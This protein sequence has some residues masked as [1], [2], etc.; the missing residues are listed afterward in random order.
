MIKVSAL[1]PYTDGAEF[2]M[3]YYVRQHIPMVQDLLGAALKGISVEHGV[4]G[5]TPDAA[6]VYV[7]MGH[8]LFD[9]TAAFNEAFGPH[10]DQIMGDI[11]NYTDQQ[12][13]LQISE[14][15]TG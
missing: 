9:S 12:P 14:V 8:L 11:P 5:G 2:D 7:A 1:Y 10:A 3:D 4:A 6:P 13:V 15:V